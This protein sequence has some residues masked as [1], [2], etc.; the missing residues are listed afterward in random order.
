M[1][2]GERTRT[3]PGAA[4]REGWRSSPMWQ[5][6]ATMRIEAEGAR[7]TFAARLARENG[8]SAAHAAAVVEEYRR[9]LYLAAIAGPVTPSE[10]VDQAWHLHLSFTRHYWEMLCGETIGTPLHHDPTEGGPAQWAHYH[11]QYEETL[12]RYRAIFGAAP[13]CEIWPDAAARFAARPLRIDAG[14]YWLL[15]KAPVR[16]LPLFAGAAMLVAA[17]TTLAANSAGESGPMVIVSILLLISFVAVGVAVALRGSSRKG[18]GGGCG[19]GGGGC[20]SGGHHG[21]GGSGCGGG[22]GCGGGCGG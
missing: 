9:F 16:R 17:C 13:P 3:G 8:W 7:L 5:R 11:R 21:D 14:R 20:S 6:L 19:G 1:M 12:A 15:P 10:D 4:D 2:N 18:D 22:G